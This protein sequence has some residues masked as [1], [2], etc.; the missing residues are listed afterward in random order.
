MLIWYGWGGNEFRDN[1]RRPWSKAQ[2]KFFKCKVNGY[3]IEQIQINSESR[4]LRLPAHCL[5]QRETGWCAGPAVPLLRSRAGER[6]GCQGTRLAQIWRC[7]LRVPV[8][9]PEWGHFRCFEIHR[10]AQGNRTRWWERL[11]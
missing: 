11:T 6:K 9:F 2:L 10:E 8:E 5:S 4:N 7:G 1:S 3:K